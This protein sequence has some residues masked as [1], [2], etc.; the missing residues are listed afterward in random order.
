M[1][2][3]ELDWI[4]INLSYHRLFATLNNVEVKL[5]FS[6]IFI[7]SFERFLFNFNMIVNR[8]MIENKFFFQICIT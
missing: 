1:L 3:Q 6:R 5:Y 2:N 8:E 7:E 4:L